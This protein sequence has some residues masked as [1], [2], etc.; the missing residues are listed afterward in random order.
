MNCNS[1]HSFVHVETI[2]PLLQDRFNAKS[3]A[4][5]AIQTQT[6]G[7]T[8]QKLANGIAELDKALYS[9]V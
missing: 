6:V 1:N 5:A 8:L 2:R 4:T 9:Q 3:F 7:E